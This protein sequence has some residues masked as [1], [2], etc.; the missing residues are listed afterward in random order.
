MTASS[1]R[2]ALS[3]IYVYVTYKPHLYIMPY[4]KDPLP[5]MIMRA[6]CPYW[7]GL[8]EGDIFSIAWR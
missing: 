5:M 7:A 8:G 1:E 4:L 6:S 3:T 2:T